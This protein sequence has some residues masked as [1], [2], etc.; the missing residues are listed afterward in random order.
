MNAF[1]LIKDGYDLF[2][3]FNGVILVY[4]D[5]PSEYFQIVDQFPYL[6]YNAAN[7]TSGHGLPPEIKV[8]KWRGDMTVRGKYEEYLSSDE[9]S[10]YLENDQLVEFR[11]PRNPF[12][13]R[14][15]TAWEFMGQEV[16]EQYLKLLNN[17][18]EDRRYP[19]ACYDAPS[20]SASAEVVGTEE[21]PA[22]ASSGSAPAEVFDVE[23]E[24]ST[25]NNAETQTVQIMSEN[26]W[27]LYHAGVL[28]LRDNKGKR[29]TNPHGE[30]VLVLRELFMLS[31]SQQEDLRARGITR[32]VWERFPLAQFYFSLVLGK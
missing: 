25:L 26:P 31:T 28:T 10:K 20:G 29:V 11:I 5:L 30:P 14:R 7:R 32:H 23:A 3:T 16:P 9:I 22:E 2:L 1:K 15:Q 19:A 24:I 8:G 4:D 13:T 17:L 27:R 18:Y 12:P 21:Q 6:G